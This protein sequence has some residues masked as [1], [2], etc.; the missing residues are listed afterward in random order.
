MS[1]FC[2]K[3]F[4]AL[5]FTALVLGSCQR[6]YYQPN[7][8][9]TPL[10]T[11][12]GNGNIDVSGM[13]GSAANQ[14]R[15]ATF[16]AQA[17]YAPLP[18]FGV[19]ATYST[20]HYK[21]DFPIPNVG[22]VESR[23]FIAEAG[24]GTFISKGKLMADLYG[25]NGFGK[26]KADINMDFRRWFLQP[27]IGFK[28]K[29]FEAAFNYRMCWI[30]YAALNPNGRDKDYLLQKDLLEKDGTTITNH[31]FFFGESALTLRG[32]YDWVKLQIQIVYARNRKV[33]WNYSKVY[34]NAG[35]QFSLPKNYFHRK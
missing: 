23:A 33:E 16:N 27:G 4:I 15:N 20:L 21:P 13:V 14:G 30:K 22:F 3:Q 2:L 11:E 5:I 28:S 7:A 29:W 12:K 26:M 25:G 34:Y 18:H 24:I 35:I 32:G 8:V 17:A 6:Y 1:H 10:L 9:N 31:N 19:M